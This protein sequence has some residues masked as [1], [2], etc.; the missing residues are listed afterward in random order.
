MKETRTTEYKAD[1]TA[2]FL[3]T[4]SA[5]ANYTSGVI[6]FGVDNEGRA[7][8]V[9]DPRQT[10]L[11]IENRINDSL[12]PIPDYSL[13]VNWRTKVITL[14]VEKG[15][16]TP[17]LYKGKAYRRSDTASVEVDQVELRRLVLDGQH[18]YFEKLAYGD[19]GLRFSVLQQTMQDKLA[20]SELTDDILRTLG[21]LTED[22]RYNNAAALFSDENRFYGVDMARF[23]KSINEIM[24]RETIAHVSVLKQYQDAIKLFRKYYQYEVI[25]G[26]ERKK[27]EIVPENAFREAMANALVHRTWDVDIHIRVAM[28]ADRIE[29]TSPGG[30]PTGLKEEEYLHGY[31]SNL[32]NPVI[33]N[34]FFRLGLIEMFGTG[35]RR[36]RDCYSDN[37]H[38]PQ[39]VITDQSITVI[40]PVLQG[41]TQIT[42]DEQTVLNELKSGMQLASGELAERTGFKREK[43]IRLLNQLIKRRYVTVHGAGR[44]TRYSI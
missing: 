26:V 40:L 25:D 41:I 17:Y 13:S 18:M 34:V 9:K 1:I 38:K 36:I 3:K 6:L 37:I 33:G 44:G 35:I 19:E 39:F 42:P 16:Y 7:V 24:D 14:S 20:I 22:K 5:Y 11:D 27:V 31:I 28:F 12:S 43:V 21:F 10:C 23:G 15:Q 8:G 4:V 29:I 2:S 30:L 32:R